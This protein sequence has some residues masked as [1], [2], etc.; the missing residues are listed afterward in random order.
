MNSQEFIW[1]LENNLNL[2]YLND[3]S[4]E[5]TKVMLSMSRIL[6]NLKILNVK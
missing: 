1:M 3:R 4:N 5:T 6:D 2:Q